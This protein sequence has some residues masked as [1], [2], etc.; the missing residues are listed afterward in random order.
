MQF[1]DNKLERLN[2]SGY[3]G[4]ISDAEVAWLKVAT[5]WVTGDAAQYNDLWRRFL[6]DRG[7]DTGDN[8]DDLYAYLGANGYDLT[9]HLAD[10]MADFW[11]DTL[12]PL[13]GPIP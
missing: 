3:D 10:R 12:T 7:F 13:P 5:G 6:D 1:N 9:G 11:A 8:N 4:N 2:N